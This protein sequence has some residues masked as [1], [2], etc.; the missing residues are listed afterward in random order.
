MRTVGIIAEYN[1]FHRGHAWQLRQARALA[2]AD[3]AVV[4][5][6]A[7][8]TQRGEAALLSPADRARMAL[9]CGADAVFALP[10][11]W[12]VR[13][14]EH[15][16][17]G[18]V[19]LLHALGVDAISFG[20]EAADVDLLWRAARLL[21]APDERLKA[22]L[23]EQLGRGLPYP[24]ALG[25]AVAALDPEAAAL[26][27]SPNN[28]LAVCYLR[29]MLRLGSTMDVCPVP[30]QGAYHDTSLAD[31]MPSATALRG[32][33]LRGDWRG[34]ERA[35]PGEAYAVLR[36][37]ALQGRLHRPEALDLPLL[38]RLRAMTEAE[39]RA[40][41]DLSEGI[42]L[43][44]LGA[45]EKARTREELLLAAKTR[46]YPH[47]RLSRLCAHALLGID[48][49][50]LAGTPLPP[51]AWLLGL[52]ASAR[53]LMAQLGRSGFPIIAKAADADRSQAWFQAELRAY[54]IWALGAGMPAGLALNMGV[55]RVDEPT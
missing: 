18:G 49:G 19:S 42:D 25:A 44:L 1:P 45:A 31:G 52:Q 53:P 27:A 55:V 16:A 9:L 29:A 20:A 11:L 36:E 10:A 26:L 39:R 35:M 54:D 34:A 32:A 4:V 3:A 13:D 17:L 15:F 37:A 40:L 23:Q 41:P 33:I 21:E 22:A 28:T 30:R 24:A 5:M 43:R 46:R 7:C 14:A 6:S 8:F 50:L 51:A 38:Y 48:A 2:R 47:A 12:S